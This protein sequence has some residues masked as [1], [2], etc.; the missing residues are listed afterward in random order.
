MPATFASYVPYSRGV[1]IVDSSFIFL[2]KEKDLKVVLNLS[3]SQDFFPYPKFKYFFKKSTH[4]VPQLREVVNVFC[5]LA[6][7]GCTHATVL[8]FSFL[9]FYA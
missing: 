6:F 9:I 3:P 1:N 2:L 5:S 8:C 7:G 4:P